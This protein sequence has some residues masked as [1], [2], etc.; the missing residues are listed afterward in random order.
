VASDKEITSTEKLLDVIRGGVSPE[1]QDPPKPETPIRPQIPVTAGAGPRQKGLSAGVDIGYTEVRIVKVEPTAAGGW[2]LVDYRAVPFP[3]G[4]ERGTPAF[5]LFLKETLGAYCGPPRT[6]SLWAMMSAANAEVRN[7]SVPKVARRELRNAVFWSAKKELEFDEET[8]VFDFEIQGEVVESGIEKY[9]VLFYVVPQKDV[10]EMS[11]LFSAAGY[12]LAG[13]TI[14]PLA[15][16]NIFRTGWVPALDRTVASLY[17][18]RDWSRIDIYSNGNLVMTRGTKAGLGSMVESLVDEYAGRRNMRPGYEP[19]DAPESA[20]LEMSLDDAGSLLRALSPD[21]A[22]EKELMGQYGLDE[23]TIFRFAAPAVERLV[24]QVERTFEHYTV[25]LGRE[26]ISEIYV[27]MGMNIYRPMVDYIGSQINIPATVLDPLNPAH[28]W[29]LGVTA[30]DSLSVRSGLVPVLGVALSHSSRSLNLIFT[31][32]DRDKRKR[33]LVANAAVAAVLGV[34]LLSGIGWYAWILSEKSDRNARVAAIEADLA[35]GV[36]VNE[37]MLAG[38]MADLR[39]KRQIV[40]ETK[41]R[42]LSVALFGEVSA[43][44]PESIRLMSVRADLGMNGAGGATPVLPRTARNAMIDGFVLGRPE[45]P[46][47]SLEAD[48]IA[49]VMNLQTSPLFD[50]VVINAKSSEVMDGR[51]VLRFTLTAAMKGAST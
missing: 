51:S 40:S 16:R 44:T 20:P 5:Q 10:R 32:K 47:D 33:F 7:I 6:V 24:R 34:L 27:S 37:T 21:S 22:P 14:A 11:A 17:I 29:V 12:P 1:I 30:G 42:F 8:T 28:P 26:S 35:R 23:E 50:R 45:S 9:S 46:V 49:Y 13:L 18:G 43:I 4:V 3:E 39:G 38:M 41:A 2:R 19:A 48:L 15:V 36:A 25:N 31:R